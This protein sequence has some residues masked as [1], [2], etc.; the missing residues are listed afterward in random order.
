MTGPRLAMKYYEADISQVES[1]T[2][3]P[4][5]YLEQKLDGVRCL[6]VLT[7][8]RVSFLSHGGQS[9]KHAASL[10]RTKRIQT[11][12]EEALVPELH[13]DYEVV[14]DGELLPDDG[15]YVIF[16]VPYARED[17][18]E[19]VTPDQPLHT[20]WE[21]LDA[22]APL[23]D[24]DGAVTVIRQ[25]RTTA[26]KRRLIA[27]AIDRGAEGLIVKLA[28]SPYEPGKRV[29]HSLKV[30]FVKTADVFITAVDKP[31]PQH[32]NARL[33]AYV[34]EGESLRI[35]DVGSCSLIG[36]PTVEVGDVIE[37]AYLY[38]NKRLV[39]PRM[40]KIRGDKTMADCRLDQFKIY[41][42]CL[43]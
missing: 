9:L 23:F 27:E 8:G 10:R 24:P 5:T 4:G 20:R 32:G 12:L 28:V 39:Q 16:D 41:T 21:Y 22:I 43:L 1:L 14:L 26:A 40:K 36:K 11:A 35:V 33:A 25:A 29:R 3:Q 13:G 42:R 38:F 2:L 34:E 17:G 15:R 18:E 6:T 37:V 7:P 30:K 31:D 19:Y